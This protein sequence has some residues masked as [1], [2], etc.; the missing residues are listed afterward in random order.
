M[1]IDELPA[2]RR[3]SGLRLDAVLG[4]WQRPGP[5]YVA[6]ADAL[7]AAILSG[8]VPLSTRLPS[9]RELA[10][11]AGVS[12]TTTTATYGLLRD[13]GYL[14]S[15]RGSGTVTT[16]PSGPGAR[17]VD[18]GVRRARAGRRRPR[19]GGSVGTL[20]PARRLPRRARRAPPAPVRHGLLAARPAGAARGRRR[21]GTPGAARPRARTRCSITT[22]AQQ[23]IH[24]LVTAHAGPGDRVVVEH[25]TYP[26]AIDVVRERR[27]PPGA[28]PVRR[29]R[30]GHRPARVDPAAGVAPAGLPDPRPPQP[31][32]DQPRRRGARPG[33]RPGPAVPHG[34]RR[35]RGPDRADH[36]RPGAPLV[37]RRR[38]GVGLRRLDRLGV[39][40]LL[41]RPAGRLGPRAPRPGRPARHHARAHRHRDSGAGAAGR[42]RAARAARPTCW[43][44]DGPSCARGAT[45]WSACC[46]TSCRPGASTCPRA[47]CRSGRTWAH[48]CPARSPR[49]PP[50]TASGW[51]PAR[52]SGWTAA[53]SGTCGCRSPRHP[54]TCAEPSPGWPPR[55]RGWAITAPVTGPDRV[56]ALV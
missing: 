6:L 42:G 50:G 23:A 25:P 15:R 48:P 22:G 29:L 7:R 46:S 1:T 3:I 28:G 55:G 18:G 44:A 45:C 5:A 54:T 36:G 51:C 39:Q 38:H 16:L 37:R 52:R 8:S 26:H 33:A 40:E 47:G 49:S 41:G 21:A 4:A 30:S 32:R 43:T 34:D 31:H 24:L 27:R 2:D 9:E 17:V 12:R 19:D 53:S 13:E 11:A 35:R 20:V 14:V 56:H 10:D